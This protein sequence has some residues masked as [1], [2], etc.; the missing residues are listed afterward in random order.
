M[1][2]GLARAVHL[3]RAWWAGMKHAKKAR[4]KHDTKLFRAGLARHDAPCWVWAEV[5]AHGRARARP[6]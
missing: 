1:L 4:P 2:L 5:E 3:G 6:V